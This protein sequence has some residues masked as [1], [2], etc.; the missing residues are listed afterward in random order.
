MSVFSKERRGVPLPGR[1]LS[2]R[3][4]GFSVYFQWSSRTASCAGRRLVLG[5]GMALSLRQLCLPLEKGPGFDT[6]GSHS[7]EIKTVPNSGTGS[8]RAPT[9]W[10]LV[11][12]LWAKSTPSCSF[13]WPWFAMLFKGKA[14][15]MGGW[16]S[17][18]A[19]RLCVCPSTWYRF[20]FLA[21]A[22]WKAQ[23]WYSWKSL[24]RNKKL[25]LIQAVGLAF[26]S[27]EQNA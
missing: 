27:E 1:R 11:C 16:L 15:V 4:L 19:L 9:S 3:L 12:L 23:F 13:G 10:P 21:S 2:T 5:K 7:E 14:S 20:A 6:P 22:L 18:Q 8:G 17:L 25:C 24:G 26:S